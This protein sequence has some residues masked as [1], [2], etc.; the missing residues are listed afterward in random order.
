MSGRKES[1]SFCVVAFIVWSVGKPIYRVRLTLDLNVA[2]P[3]I[4]VMILDKTIK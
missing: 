2:L 3:L 1:E 4:T